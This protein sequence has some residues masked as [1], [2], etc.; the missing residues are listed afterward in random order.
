[1]DTPI[2]AD[3]TL[4]VT[5]LFCPIPIIRTAERIRG[6]ATGQ[7]LEVLAT[8]FGILEDMPAWCTATGHVYL[9]TR[10]ESAIYHSFIRRGR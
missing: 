6:M 8:D 9:G 1:M 3:L 2:A 10:Q 5:G 7:V 4:D